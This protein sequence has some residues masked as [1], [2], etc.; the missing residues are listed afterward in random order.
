MFIHEK[1]EVVRTAERPSGQASEKTWWG[2]VGCNVVY[3]YTETVS[4]IKQ[5]GQLKTV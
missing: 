4:M 3:R 1:P 2:K 5:S